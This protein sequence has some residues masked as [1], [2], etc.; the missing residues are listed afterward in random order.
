MDLSLSGASSSRIHSMLQ[1]VRPYW[2]LA[3]LLIA[4]WWTVLAAQQIST[5]NIKGDAAQNLEI[6][7]NLAR[8]GKFAIHGAPTDLREPLPIAVVA[9]H[10]LASGREPGQ[11][12]MRDLR[13]GESARFVKLHNM[14]WVFLGLVGTWLLFNELTETRWWG[15]LA[16]GASFLFFFN[17]AYVVDS[18]YTELHTGVLMI[19]I[20]WLMLLASRRQSG[21]LWLAAGVG[22]GLLCLTK[23]AF[24]Y[25]TLVTIALMAVVMLWQRKGIHRPWFAAF[26]MTLGLTC[27]I[28]PWM[29]RNQLLFDSPQISAGRGGWVLYKRA[30]LNQMTDEEFKLAFALFGP[31]LYLNLV[32]GT[33]LAITPED[34]KMRSGRISRLYA[35]G[36]EFS[37]EDMLAQSRGEPERAISLYRKTSALHVKL[38]REMKQAGHPHP[39]LAADQKMQAMAIRMIAENPLA[40][41]KLTSLMFWRGT[42]SFP[43]QLDIPL[44]PEGRWRAVFIE[45]LNAVAMLA[46]LVCFAY[47]LI[48][49]NV[50]LLAFTVL[51]VLM[52]AFYTLLS[53]NLPRFFAPAQPMMLMAVLLLLFFALRSRLERASLDE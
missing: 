46:L 34:H 5:A 8:Q 17:N 23:S 21:P 24:L 14:G 16:A 41:L 38:S 45:S 43:P 4:G 31:R 18:L 12:T 47:A 50:R 19:V 6:A 28:A 20:A 52:M 13:G 22:M 48:R 39:E 9:L 27:T 33:S 49:R 25:V 10:I 2:W 26:L 36:S 44:L 32:S 53:Q 35:G 37:S 1:R 7:I 3:M 15:G 29:I 11:I 40:H 30:L 51:P 42:W